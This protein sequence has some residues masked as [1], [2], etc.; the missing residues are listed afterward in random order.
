VA[1]LEIDYLSE[2]IITASQDKVYFLDREFLSHGKDHAISRAPHTPCLRHRVGSW[3]IDNDSDQNETIVRLWAK[4]SERKYDVPRHCSFALPDGEIELRV[5]DIERYV[6]VLTVS[7]SHPRTTRPGTHESGPGAITRDGLEDAE[8]RVRTLFT[9]KPRTRTVLAALYREY[10]TAGAGAPRPLTREEARR[11]LSMDSP[12]SIDTAL[13]DVQRAIW[14]EPGHAD[15]I[16]VYLI[17]RG[18]L[19][20]EHQGMVPH[21]DCAHRRPGR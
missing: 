1:D 9:E 11:C 10:L 20:P 6:M 12:S 21:R 18:L 14:G 15:K 3:W 16:P 2:P 5:W 8:E 19:K 4:T 17:N 13:Q 7:G